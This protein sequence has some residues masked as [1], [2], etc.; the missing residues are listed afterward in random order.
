MIE[1]VLR[2]WD[3]V[4]VVTAHDAPTGA[5]F[6]I[7][8]HD[9]TLGPM[10][11]AMRLAEGMTHKWAAI[12]MDYGGGKGVIALARPVENGARAGL[13]AR[14]ARL[15][16]SL[17]GSFQTGQDLGTTPGDMLAIARVTRYV[18]GIDHDAMRAVDPGPYTARGVFVGLR[19]AVR[20]VFDG[21]ALAGRTVLLQGVGDVGAPLARLLAADGVKLLVSDV[22]EARAQGLARELGGAAV[23]ADRVY[24]TACDV[25]APCAIGATVNGETIPRLRCR[26][27]AGSANNQLGGPDD[28]ARLHARGILYAPDYII[29]GGGATAF[30]HLARGERD[31]TTLMRAVERIEQ[32]LD[33]IFREAAEKNESPV[34]AA[35]RL[36]DTRLA[37]RS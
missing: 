19:A 4:G 24:D 28:A 35:R 26:I 23:P 27:V 18:H 8:L 10:I 31:E 17:G 9:A 1:D 25:Y 34:H 22:D 20:H 37:R 6:F 12:G 30:G 2:G 5:W 7:A 14:W 13:F 11:D 16:Q 36:V 29:N 15:I 21:A 33:G 32:V 3:G